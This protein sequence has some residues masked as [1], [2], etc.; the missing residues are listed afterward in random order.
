MLLEELLDSDFDDELDL[1]FDEDEELD[2]REYIAVLDEL[3]L[4]DDDE[5][6]IEIR[7]VLVED[8]DIENEDVDREDDELDEDRDSWAVDDEDIDTSTVLLLL[9]VEVLL[10]D[11]DTST[12]ELDELLDRE[13]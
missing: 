9:D 4:A 13:T 7:T 8:E 11:I 6:D 1:L 12:V 5:L 3:V 2:D 10:E